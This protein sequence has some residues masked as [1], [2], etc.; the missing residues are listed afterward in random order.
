M[1]P[2]FLEIG[3]VGKP[4]GLKG[5]FRIISF[6]SSWE[7]FSPGTTVYLGRGEE[8]EAHRIS[9]AKPQG[10]TVVIRLAE[11]ENR[12]AVEDLG[13]TAIYIKKEELRDLPANEFYWAELIG[14][15]VFDDQGRLM[16]AV[17]DIFTTPAHD[18]W[19]IGDQEKEVLIPAID[20]FVASVDTV[21]KKICLKP[22]NGLDQ[23]N[24]L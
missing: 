17:K 4:S 8:R 3:R 18:I 24:D 11:L 16:G 10:N 22:L 6:A 1:K 7:R 15:R 5:H 14:S 20:E 21:Q 2:G 19:V 23:V 9:E 13:G 12:Q